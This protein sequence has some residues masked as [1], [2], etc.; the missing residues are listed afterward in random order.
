[1]ELAARALKCVIFVGAK[2][3]SSGVFIPYGTAFLA[4]KETDQIQF[5]HLITARHVIEQIPG[6]DIYIRVNDVEGGSKVLPTNRAAY[7]YVLDG[8]KEYIDVAV[9][10]IVLQQQYFDI[11]HVDIGSDVIRPEEESFPT[12][13]GDSVC[14]TGLF[15]SH[16]GQ[17]RNIP[18]A[19]F[20]NVSAIGDEPVLTEYGFMWGYLV[21]LKSLGGLSGSPVFLQKTIEGKVESFLFGLMHG[22]FVVENPEDAISVSGKDKPTGQINT[23]IGLVI[24]IERVLEVINQPKLVKQRKTVVEQIISAPRPDAPKGMA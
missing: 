24:P 10:P 13:V 4:M 7:W 9:C 1:M 6:D 23:G 20:G 17:D 22:H 3:P 19:R 12:N 14:V 5:Q 15:T 16:Y 11:L 8:A 2:D 18:I 21:E